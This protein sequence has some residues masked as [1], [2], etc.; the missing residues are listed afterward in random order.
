LAAFSERRNAFW[1]V[2]KRKLGH[3]KIVLEYSLLEFD[4]ITCR[5]IDYS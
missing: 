2:E 1:R 5:E 3:V 4:L